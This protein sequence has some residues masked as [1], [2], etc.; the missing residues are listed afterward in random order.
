MPDGKEWGLPPPSG[1]GPWSGLIGALQTG[2]ADVGWANLFITED[3]KAFI[4]YSDW[5]NSV[6]W[7][8]MV[9]KPGSLPKVTFALFYQGNVFFQIGRAHV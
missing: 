6:T 3:R 7:C 2:Q 5:Y 9:K 4:D 8:A 1:S